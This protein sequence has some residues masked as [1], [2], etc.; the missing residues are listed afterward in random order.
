MYYFLYLGLI[1]MLWAVTT[2]LLLLSQERIFQIYDC[3]EILFYQWIIKDLV[4]DLRFGGCFCLVWFLFVF[5][6]G[7]WWFDV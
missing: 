1:G 2:W 3:K 6:R 4:A 7:E 5:L